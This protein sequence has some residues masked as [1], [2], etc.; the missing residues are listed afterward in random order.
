MDEDEQAEEADSG[1]EEESMLR[2]SFSPIMH[3]SSRSVRKGRSRGKTKKTTPQLE[4]V[5]VMKEL[6]AYTV[7]EVQQSSTPVPSSSTTPL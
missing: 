5:N 7:R 3:T 2:S 4:L 1:E 6:V